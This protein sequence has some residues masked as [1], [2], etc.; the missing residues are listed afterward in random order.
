[1]IWPE[2]YG[3][4]VSIDTSWVCIRWPRRNLIHESYE[5]AFTNATVFFLS[6]AL[7]VKGKNGKPFRFVFFP[8]QSFDPWNSSKGRFAYF[9]YF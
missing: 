5:K 4:V 7:K 1:M 8:L 9:Y 6:T 3:R 2:M